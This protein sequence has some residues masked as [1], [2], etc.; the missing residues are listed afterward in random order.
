MRTILI[1]TALT[2]ACHLAHAQHAKDRIKV[3]SALSLMLAALDTA[4]GKASGELVGKQASTVAKKYGPSEALLIDVST[5]RKLAQQGCSL[6]H[7]RFQQIRVVPPGEKKPRNTSA[8]IEIGL[9]RD[10]SQPKEV[11][12][13]PVQ[14]PAQTK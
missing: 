13:R 3:E 11:A 5:V 14:P 1:V 4:D 10:G 2:A 7:V 8:A 9:C 6:L 12:S